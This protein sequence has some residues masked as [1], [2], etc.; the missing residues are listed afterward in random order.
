MF[1]SGFTIIGWEVYIEWNKSGRAWYAAV[2]GPNLELCGGR[3]T[4][5]VSRSAQRG[6]D[7]EV[8]EGREPG[9]DPSAGVVSEN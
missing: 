5:Q 9:H 1:W 7:Y 4:V 8:Y 6:I 2:R 3:L